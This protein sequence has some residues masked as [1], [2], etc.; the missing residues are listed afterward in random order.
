MTRQN[1]YV[2]TKDI[3]DAPEII[4]RPFTVDVWD[5]DQE[6]VKLRSHFTCEMRELWETAM[7]AF[8][9]GDW[10]RSKEN[11]KLILKITDGKDGPTKQLL[12]KIA[13]IDSATS[14]VLPSEPNAQNADINTGV[15]NG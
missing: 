12:M 8:D 4:L 6:L 14:T 3:G 9:E 7:N 11:L 10:N 2:T 5:N 15:D 13:M 1:D